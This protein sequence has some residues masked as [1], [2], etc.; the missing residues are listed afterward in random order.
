LTQKRLSQL[1]GVSQ[2]HIVKI[3][4]G[5]VDPGLYKVNKILQVLTEGEGRTCKDIMT[6]NVIFAK[7]N[8]RVLTVDH[9]MMERGISQLPVI[10]SE[11]P[12]GTV[13]EESIIKNLHVNIADDVVEKIVG[14]SCPA[15]LRIRA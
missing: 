14:H 11:K 15:F 8:D 4:N 2:A 6:R 5:G 7:P 1:V 13:T 12:V 9:I 3:E 10:Q